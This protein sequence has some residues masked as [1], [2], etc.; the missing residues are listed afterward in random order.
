MPGMY[1]WLFRIHHDK[2]QSISLLLASCFYENLQ[3]VKTLSDILHI[4]TYNQ[5]YSVTTKLLY[6]I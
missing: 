5:Y 4:I 3:K 6:L 2:G 1:F